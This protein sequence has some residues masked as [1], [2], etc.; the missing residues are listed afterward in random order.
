MQDSNAVVKKDILHCYKW[1]D[2]RTDIIIREV[3][4]NVD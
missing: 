3:Y 2:T 4:Q 1:Q